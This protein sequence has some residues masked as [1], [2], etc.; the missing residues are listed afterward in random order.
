[1]AATTAKEAIVASDDSGRPLPSGAELT[2]LDEAFRADPYP[3]LERLRDEKRVHWDDGLSRWFI[4]GFEEVRAVLRNKEMSSNPHNAVANSYSARIIA[5]A[6]DAGMS[7]LFNSILF[8]DDP[9]HRRLRALVSKPFSAKAVELLRPR[10]R[11]FAE[12][13]LDGITD[14]RFDL[15]KSFA[16]PLPVIIIA[17]ML[18]VDLAE[19]DNFKS[20]SET[21]VA[22]FFNP[23]RDAAQA[24]RGAIAAQALNEY[25]TQVVESRRRQPA[26][27]LISSMITSDEDSRPL[28]TEEILAECQLLLVAGNVTTTDLIGNSVKALLTH[29]EQLAV[30]RADP[31]LI[32]EAIEEVLR[33]D[34]PVVQAARVIPRDMSFEGCPFHQGQS[35][36]LSLAG[37]NRDPR[38]NPEPDRFDIRRKDIRH[39]SFGGNKHLCLGA[40]LARVEAQ[41]AVRALLRRY[42]DLELVQ[43]EYRYR[44]WPAFRG[45]QELWLS[46]G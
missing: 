7:G 34:S 27:D 37:A 30:L 45:M 18:G 39:H 36:T 33:Y 14:E 28:S 8:I 20:W 46:R 15:M 26:D 44:P 25:L 5:G 11:E 35:I 6:R 31:D 42:P 10:I 1:M 3:V 24:A 4:T 13:L 40:A 22:T 2:P 41:E 21:I 17:E 32:T 29:P 23:L 16:E 9:D 12:Q 43:Q 38:A 19:R